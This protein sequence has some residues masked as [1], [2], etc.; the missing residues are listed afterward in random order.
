MLPKVVKAGYPEKEFYFSG[1]WEE[2]IS[3]GRNVASRNRRKHK[4][5]IYSASDGGTLLLMWIHQQP[6]GDIKFLNRKRKGKG[7]RQ[8]DCGHIPAI[9][10]PSESG[11]EWWMCIN[12]KKNR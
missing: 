4:V 5:P 3:G 6:N 10:P 2:V 11:T 9:V 7:L 12:C 8:C 1:C